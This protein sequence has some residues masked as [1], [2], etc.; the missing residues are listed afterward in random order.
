MRHRRPGAYTGHRGHNKRGTRAIKIV[1]TAG[2]TIEAIDPV[3]FISN[4][5]TGRMGYK[6]AEVASKRGNAITLISGPTRLKPPRVKKFISIETA[7]DLFRVLKKE[8]KRADCLVMCAAVADFRRASVPK[9][10]IKRKKGLTLRLISNK[11]ILKALSGYKKSK[12]FVGFSLETE[13][14]VRNAR[15]KIKNKNLDII[16]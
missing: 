7:G 1:I 5:S 2:P 14:V 13:G 4:R 11:D 10:K 15:K 6:I 16:V 8:I 3:R 12:L 9:G